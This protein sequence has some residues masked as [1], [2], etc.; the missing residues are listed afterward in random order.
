MNLSDMH[1][2]NEQLFLFISGGSGQYGVLDYFFLIV[3][4]YLVPVLVIS[5][6]IWFFIVP[7]KRMK[8]PLQRLGTYKHA[9]LLAISVMLVWA[10]TEFIKGLVAFPRPA[11][12]LL[13]LEPLS[14]FGSYDSFPSAHTAFAFMIATFVY[15]YFKR[16]GR[17]LFSL[18]FL[19]GISRM[20]VGVHF[21]LDVFVG[22]LIGIVIPW[23]I[24]ST[25]KRS[26]V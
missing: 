12:I 15:H 26:D 21:P 17:L 19:V 23:G 20:Y 24:I 10:V 14:T 5:T 4:N 25:F 11:Q 3:T 2:L 6:I 1:N 13:D 8:D 16:A 18:A 7:P 22:A 9:G